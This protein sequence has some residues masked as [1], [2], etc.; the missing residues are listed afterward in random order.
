[1]TPPSHFAGLAD[2]GL[3]LQALFNLRDLPVTLQSQLAED[4]ADWSQLLLLGHAGPTLWH[5]LTDAGAVS[6][7]AVA[8]ADPIDDYSRAQ[9]AR[10]FNDELAG[11]RYRIIYPGSERVAL[12]QLGALAGWHHSSPFRVGISERWGSWFAYRAVVL[13][14]TGLHPFS[15]PV[16][17]SPCSRC[18]ERPCITSCSGQV[19]DRPDAT[20]A[21]IRFRLEHNSP[22][23]GHCA[24]RWAC[25]VAVEERYSAEQFHYHYRRSLQTLRCW[26]VQADSIRK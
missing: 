21:C 16:G 17:G 24:A 23:A 8:R 20:A 4:A 11:H 9:V 3:N 26:A 14:D 18:V 22:C 7:D 2:A 12:Q 1:M 13:T 25:P 6:G 5:Q 15:T 19:L 10:L